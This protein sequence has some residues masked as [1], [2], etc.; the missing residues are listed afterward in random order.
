MKQLLPLLGFFSLLFLIACEETPDDFQPDFAHYY[1]PLEDGRTLTYEVDSVYFDLTADNRVD[2]VRSYVQEIITGTLL[3]NEGDTIYRIEHF[4]RSTPDEEWQITDVYTE[5]LHDNR[6]YRTEED[7]RLHKLIFPPTV[8]RTWD[9]NIEV[10]ELRDIPVAGQEMPF[11]KS[12]SYRVLSVGE[13]FQDT[14]SNE[15]YP[16][17]LTIQVAD[18]ENILEYRYGIERYAKDIGL[19]YRELQ[20]IDTQCEIC[21]ANDTGE[22]CDTLSWYDKGEKGLI[23]RQRLIEN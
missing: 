11:F 22:A 5:A 2:S 1:F 14:V 6:A 7:I 15:N 20:I 21:C 9:G 23:L 17:V 3:D 13:A 8:N 12:W 10:D 19:I 18:S 16:D 4:E